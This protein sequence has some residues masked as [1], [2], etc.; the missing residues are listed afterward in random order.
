[1][2]A[3]IPDFNSIDP[4][5]MCNIKILRSASTVTLNRLNRS[6]RRRRYQQGQ[7]IL[8]RGDLQTEVML[9][10]KGSV[11]VTLFSPQ[12]REVSIR[13]IEAGDVFGDYAA[14]DQAPRSADII[15]LTDVEVGLLSATEFI[16]MVTSDPR[17]AHAQM[18][19]LVEMIRLLS[20]RVYET[21]T[22]SASGRIRATLLRL[23]NLTDYTHARIETL[24]THAEIAAMS[25]SQRHVVTTELQRLKDAGLIRKVESGLEICDV[26]ALTQPLS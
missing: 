15:A 17:V 6:C 8:A 4:V 20:E 24:P 12:G 26:K 22:L 21:T 19:E 16:T 7:Q 11:K 1:M 5:E 2:N 18:K 9:L 25:G 10:F 13:R 3:P 14:L 23:A